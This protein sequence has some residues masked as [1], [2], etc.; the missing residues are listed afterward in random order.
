MAEE[1]NYEPAT[2][3]EALNNKADRDFNNISSD[4]KN[5]VISWDRIDW[6][7]GVSQTAQIEYTAPTNGFIIGF[8]YTNGENKLTINNTTFNFNSGNGAN[9]YAGSGFYIPLSKNDTYKMEQAFS[10]STSFL[11]FYPLKGVNNA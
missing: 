6:E 9:I 7:S 5:M 3:L 11:T 8:N 4:T 1:V 2:V 10:G